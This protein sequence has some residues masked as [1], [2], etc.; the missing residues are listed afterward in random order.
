MNSHGN[1][2]MNAAA[3]AKD[4]A[5]NDH[6]K[7]KDNTM[8][9]EIPDT[10]TGEGHPVVN[11]RAI[12]QTFTGYL[13]GEP[14]TRGRQGPDG[15]PVL[16]PNGQPAKELVVT[17]IAGPGS[18]MVTGTVATP[19]PITAGETVRLILRGGGFA[20]WITAKSA[21]PKPLQVGDCVTMNCDRAVIYTTGGSPKTVTTPAEV[22]AAPRGTQIGHYS[23]ITIERSTDDAMTLAAE[24]AYR[25]SAAITLES[26]ADV[27]AF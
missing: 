15:D 14:L 10:S 16:K 1:N 3:A 11:A 4:A 23:S 26:D 9:I 24:N 7:Q 12:G 6:P 8:P 5:L 13:C 22:D 20:E 18:T 2:A 17:L 27:E 19:T 25:A 21:G